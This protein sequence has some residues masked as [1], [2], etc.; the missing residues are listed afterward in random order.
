M[1][2]L[3][4]RGG[5]A[6]GAGSTLGDE[7]LVLRVALGTCVSLCSRFGGNGGSLV[8]SYSGALIVNRDP[9]EV[10]PM[11]VPVMIE[12]FDIEDVVDIA[13]ATESVD[14]L[15]LSLYSDVEGASNDISEG[16]RGGRFGA[17]PEGLLGG[18]LGAAPLVG[19]F[20]FTGLG[21]NF[22]TTTLVLA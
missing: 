11:L 18:K 17:G 14:G 4:G 20:G 22:C 7:L 15:R 10:V 5:G 1:F 12:A 21:A 9:E 19:L 2:V 8:G 3:L 16:L 13:D 6:V